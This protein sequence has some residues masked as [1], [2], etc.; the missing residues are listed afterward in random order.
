MTTIHIPNG[1]LHIAESKA[2]CPACKAPQP[3]E[4]LEPKWL[5]AKGFSMRHKCTCG[6]FMHITCNYKGDFVAYD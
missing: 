4:A 3:I 1:I 6:K 5:K 2:L